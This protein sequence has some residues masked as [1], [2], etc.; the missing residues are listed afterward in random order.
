GT[1]PSGRARAAACP[2]VFSDP[3]RVPASIT[4]V[5]RLAA[6]IKRLRCRKLIIHA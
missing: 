4:T 3:E 1:A 6:A 5:A 2:A